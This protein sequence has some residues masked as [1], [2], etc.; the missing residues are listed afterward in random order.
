LSALKKVELHRQDTF[1]AT[2]GD[3]TVHGFIVESEWHGL[4]RFLDPHGR[5][6]ILYDGVVIKGSLTLLHDLSLTVPA[7]GYVLVPAR[8]LPGG[9]F[10]PAFYAGQFACSKG[11]DGKATVSADEKP[12]LSINFNDSKAACAAIGGALITES[13]WLSIALDIIEQDINWTSG[14]VGEGKVYQGLHLGTVSSAQAGSY[15]SPKSEERRWHQ[16]SNGSRVYDF[17]GNIWQRVY[18]DVQGDESGLIAKPFAIDSISISTAPKKSMENGIGW[19]PGDGRDWSGY[20]L[21]RG[22]DW[23][24]GDR[25]GVFSLSCTHPS[26]AGGGVGFRCTKSL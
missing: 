19:T 2:V 14:K 8:V 6:L 12:W 10:V 24:V 17:A 25:A 7:D 20:A 26:N 1:T 4:K 23:D 11:A 13:Q 22:G 15:E 16:L 18:D 5:D 3:K 21:V 9:K